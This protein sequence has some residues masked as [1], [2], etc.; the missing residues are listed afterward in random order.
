MSTFSRLQDDE[1]NF[2]PDKSV[3]GRS[4]GEKLIDTF[5]FEKSI[6]KFR[7]SRKSEDVQ[8]KVIKNET[9]T[10][11]VNTFLLKKLR[12]PEIIS[13]IVELSKLLDC[14]KI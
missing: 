4:Q 11:Q 10:F 6:E 14:I 5:E 9:N 7:L 2:N 13:S 8:F 1:S 12:T 3:E